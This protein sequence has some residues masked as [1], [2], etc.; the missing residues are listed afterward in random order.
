MTLLTKLLLCF[1]VKEF[2]DRWPIIM[3]CWLL[4]YQQY[5]NQHISLGGRNIAVGGV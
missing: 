1:V 2:I 3:R 5:Y 4:S